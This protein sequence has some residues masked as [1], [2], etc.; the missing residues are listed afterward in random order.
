ME[1]QKFTNQYQELFDCLRQ[2]KDFQGKLKF[3]TEINN[4]INHSMVFF[5]IGSNEFSETKSNYIIL[6]ATLS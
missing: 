6:S 5:P 4:L 2:L 1:I 3:P